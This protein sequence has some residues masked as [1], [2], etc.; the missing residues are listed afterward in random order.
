MNF[1]P[2]IVEWTEQPWNPITGCTKVSSGCVNCY[3]E[4]TAVWLQ[5]IGNRRYTNG[6][7]LTL[8]ED[9]L[10]QPLHWR[11]PR[12]V[13]IGSMSDIFHRDI[14]NDFIL[15]AFDVMNRCPQ[16]T[17]IVL[18]KRADKMETLAPE[19]NWTDN[20]WLGVTVEEERYKERIVNL[21][22]TAAVRKFIC[23]EPLIGDLG[24]VDLTGI[25]WLVIGG[26]S[27]SNC[28]PIEEDW[29]ASLRDQCN[30][31]DVMF[32]FKQWGGVKRKENGSLLQGE[33]HHS[34]PEV[35]RD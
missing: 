35:M 27:G 21:Q 30:N 4:K 23:A 13:F 16:H 5:R 10:E 18:T 17:F 2:K 3:A 1:E 25:D 14:P 26:E 9:V 32:T 29:V 34:L 15:K 11:K 24:E 19:I 12:R 20:I 31:Q 8:H 6:F 7:N 22:N 33:Y 28:R